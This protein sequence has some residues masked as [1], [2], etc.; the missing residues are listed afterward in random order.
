M[1]TKGSLREKFQNSGN[2]FSLIIVM[3]IICAAFSF[4][5]P[6]FLSVK[7][8]L[9]IAS[10]ASIIGI[11][12]AGSMIVMLLGQIDM[13][14]YAVLTLSS[15]LTAMMLEKGY[16][17]IVVIA[18]TMLVGFVC[19]LF[20]GA[21]IA[22]LKIPGI[23]CTMGTMNI[24]RGIAYLSTDGSSVMI[25]N[26]LYSFIGRGYILNRIPFSVILMAIV[27]L[28]VAYVLKYINFGR[29]IY[30]V[31]GNESAAYLAGVNSS[32]IKFG[33]LVISGLC[34]A[35]AGLVNSS[36][37]GAAVP[38]TGEGS[39]MDVLSAVILGGVSLTGGK[40]KVSGTILGVFILATI[41]NGMTLLSIQSFYQKLING[42][43]L[44]LAVLLDVLKSGA[45]KKK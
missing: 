13:S 42:T 6:Y 32:A 31:G 28:V 20:N 29:K 26:D 7:N 3:L 19:G 21:I 5:S 43:V 33:A 16:S 8:F 36:Q 39:E 24:F 15:M 34:A 44:I 45:L 27:F 11:M 1:K 14:Q 30:A 41:R 35:F 10:A 12:A 22:Y 2:T 18:A 9:N 23:I 4:M 37:V 17:V 40:G 38:S 25:K